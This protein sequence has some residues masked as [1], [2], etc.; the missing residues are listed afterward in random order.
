MT[1]KMSA[2]ASATLAC[3]LFSATTHA[4]TA[5]FS[6]VS[7]IGIHTAPHEFVFGVTDPET[8][9]RL[10]D[11]VKDAGGD[12]PRNPRV[13]GQIVKGREAYNAEWPFHLEPA[14]VRLTEGMD[15]E[16]CDATPFEIEDNLHEVGAAF[17]P[18][19]RWCP[20]SMRMVREVAY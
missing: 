20:W 15:T 17:L 3:A 14:T 16:V 4:E 8:I 2:V 7:T 12:L 5:Y 1:L 9:V 13:G 18:G 11:I 6:F 10:R 19:N